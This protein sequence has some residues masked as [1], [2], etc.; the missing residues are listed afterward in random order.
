LIRICE[1]ALCNPDAYGETIHK[2]C[3]LP[4][5]ATPPAKGRTW[6]GT[7]ILAAPKQSPTPRLRVGR[8]RCTGLAFP[9][10]LKTTRG[11]VALNA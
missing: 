5:R 4:V 6:Q 1:L 3:G 10:A 9:N 2:Y 8:G 7:S 11:E